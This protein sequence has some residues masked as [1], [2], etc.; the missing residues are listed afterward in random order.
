[1]SNLINCA[2]NCFELM[3][4]VRNQLEDITV[5]IPKPDNYGIQMINFRKNQ[6]SGNRTTQKTRNI[7]P[8]YECFTSLDRYNLKKMVL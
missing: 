7:C 8:V 6:A 2:R 3:W 1:M 4:I 5:G